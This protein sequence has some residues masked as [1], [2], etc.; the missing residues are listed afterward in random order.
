VKKDAVWTLRY[1]QQNVPA[2]LQI[3]GNETIGKGLCA[4]RLIPTREV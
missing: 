4:V 2:V 3:G 1:A